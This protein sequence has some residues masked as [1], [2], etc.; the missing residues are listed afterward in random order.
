M[1]HIKK[2]G[3]HATRIDLEQLFAPKA[4]AS[5]KMAVPVTYRRRKATMQAGSDSASLKLSAILADL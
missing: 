3:Q 1:I 2:S 4:T 5:A